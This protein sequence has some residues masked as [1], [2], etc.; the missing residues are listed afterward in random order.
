MTRGVT[1]TRSSLERVI[2]DFIHSG[3]MKLFAGRVAAFVNRLGAMV[4]G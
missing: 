3:A 2:K 4:F 1:L